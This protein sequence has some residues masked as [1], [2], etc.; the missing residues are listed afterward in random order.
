MVHCP[1]QRA[2]LTAKPRWELGSFAA[3]PPLIWKHAANVLG[4]SLPYCPVFSKS[5][6]LE[7]FA[8]MS[9]GW[10]ELLHIRLAVRA[11]RAHWDPRSAP[12]GP[13]PRGTGGAE[14]PLPRRPGKTC[15]SVK[16]ARFA[17]IARFAASL[18][19][20]VLFS[21]EAEIGRG[22]PLAAR[23]CKPLPILGAAAEKRV[24]VARK[25]ERRRA[26]RNL[27][28]GRSR[29]PLL[30]DSKLA[31][32]AG[33]PV[34]RRRDPASG[35]MRR[36][37]RGTD[38][39]LRRRPARAS[40]QRQ[41][42]ELS[43]RS[44]LK[45]ILRCSIA[46]LELLLLDCYIHISRCFKPLRGPGPGPALGPR[47]QGRLAALALR[48]SSTYLRASESLCL[49]SSF[50]SLS[51]SLHAEAATERLRPQPRSQGFHTVSF[52]Y[53]PGEN[54]IPKIRSVEGEPVEAWPASLRL[55]RVSCE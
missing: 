1:G 17:S 45:A 28:S 38:I 13:L 52:L 43:K 6:D 37:L 32:S 4:F 53:C 40:E 19:K 30:P 54:K 31:F 3:R 50:L 7:S 10:L 27:Y 55:G 9:R 25:E 48:A 18:E 29:A 20:K 14:V 24:S 12:S 46:A 22:T 21:A 41:A 26:P 8:E 2:H 47:F 39:A 51:L 34:T 11:N 15:R 44:C 35:A 49:V 23:T 33:R 16:I 42:Q 5:K 36:A